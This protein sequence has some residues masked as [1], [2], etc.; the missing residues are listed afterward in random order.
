ME[1]LFTVV[2]NASNQADLFEQEGSKF[3]R[4]TYSVLASVQ[5]EVGELAEEIAID[6][7]HSYKEKGADGVIGEAVDVIVAALDLIAVANP[8]M[9]EEEIIAIAKRKCNKWLSRIV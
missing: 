3:K 4:S 1:T 6:N 7:G 2:K 8:E 5:S 9:K